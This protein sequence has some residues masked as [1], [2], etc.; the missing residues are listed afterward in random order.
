MPRATAKSREIR[1][2]LTISLALAVLAFGACILVAHI[3]T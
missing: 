1:T 3:L 2:A